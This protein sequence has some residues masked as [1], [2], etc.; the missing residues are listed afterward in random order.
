MDWHLVGLFPYIEEFPTVGC[1][2]IWE[3]I[4]FPARGYG[5]MHYLE[6]MDFAPPP[7]FTGQKTTPVN[8]LASS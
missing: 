2:D 1:L 6:V 7:I 8:R 4:G 5:N 3:I